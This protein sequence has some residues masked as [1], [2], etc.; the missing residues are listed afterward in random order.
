MRF[1]VLEIILDT[2]LLVKMKDNGDT[3]RRWTT[4]V[5]V[6]NDFIC[7]LTADRMTQQMFLMDRLSHIV[8]LLVSATEFWFCLTMFC[9]D[10]ARCLNISDARP[11]FAKKYR[12]PLSSAVA[13]IPDPNCKV[14]TSERKLIP[15]LSGQLDWFS[16]VCRSTQSYSNWDRMCKLLLKPNVPGTEIV[17]EKVRSKSILFTLRVQHFFCILK[18]E[19]HFFCG[20]LSLGN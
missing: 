19:R 9:C 11:G 14:Y 16:L 6:S 20:E 1:S 12:L 5:W 2:S 10:P 7:V 15:D 3:D 17:S 18:I 4:P 8:F 13:M